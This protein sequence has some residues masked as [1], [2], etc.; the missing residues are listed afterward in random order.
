MLIDTVKPFGGVHC[1]TTATGTL[2]QHLGYSLSEP[3]LFGL[4]EGLGFVFWNM[5]SM[6]HP[7]IGGRVK[8]D[9]L[10]ETLCNNLNLTLKITE[11]SSTQK[12]WDNVA[13]HI[14]QGTPVGLKLDCYHLDY[15]ENKIHF[16]AHYAAM[17]GYDDDYAY[18][19]DTGQQGGRV[20]TSL[21]SLALARNEKGPM[22]SR[23]RAYTI[24]K[25]GREPV[26][27]RTVVKQAI[28]NNAHTFLNPPIKN[29]GYRGI[30]KT[31]SEII[32]WFNTSANLQYE[33][34]TMS[35]LMERGGTGGALFR[36]LYRDFLG[37][38]LTQFNDPALE[39]AYQRYAD[40][41]LQWTVVAERLH[42]AGETGD[43]RYVSDASEI[44]KALSEQE[45]LAMETLATFAE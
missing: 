27:L 39:S 26:D 12:A 19:I 38:C 41:A 23:N 10:T 14:D 33:F 34:Q 24:E 11:T 44:L 35:V 8:P 37:E 5:K 42:E 22:S 9:V 17:Y 1:E 36:N 30:L 20:R 13:Q 28:R 31:G 2:L 40:I 15:F 4:G 18:L 43:V 3:M 21:E 6:D 45:R 25:T 16:A 29:L 32:R 7:F